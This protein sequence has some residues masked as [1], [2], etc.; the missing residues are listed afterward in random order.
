MVVHA[1]VFDRLDPLLSGKDDRHVQL[2]EVVLGGIQGKTDRE[3]I[4][5]RQRWMRRNLPLTAHLMGI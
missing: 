3:V 1:S 5:K 4:Y 2:L